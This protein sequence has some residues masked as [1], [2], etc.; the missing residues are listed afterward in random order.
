MAAG[1]VQPPV[2]V[3]AG[4]GVVAAGNCA[5][6]SADLTACDSEAGG[7]VN[8]SAV[9][10]VAA[11][12][13]FRRVAFPD[14]SSDMQHFLLVACENALAVPPPRQRPLCATVRRLS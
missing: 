9:A 13:N 12:R 10:A 4:C 14:G 6:S 3:A 11:P 2:L 7:A 1:F 5:I 8:V